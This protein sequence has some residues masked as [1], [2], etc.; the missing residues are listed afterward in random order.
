VA[1]CSKYDP[2]RDDYVLITGAGTNG[3]DCSATTDGYTGGNYYQQ[4][5]VLGWVYPAGTAYGAVGATNSL[6]TASLTSPAAGANLLVGT[7]V[8]VS[9]TATDSDGTIAKVRFFVNQKPIGTDTSSPYSVSWTPD[10]AGTYTIT[11]VALDNRGAIKKSTS[12]SVNTG[13]AARV[14]N[15][16]FS[17]PPISSTTYLSNPT[18]LGVYWTF[19][20]VWAGGQSGVTGNFSAFT[21]GQP[22]G[23]TSG[24]NSAFIQGPNPFSQVIHF[25]LAGGH[26]ICFDSAQRASNQH[27]LSLSVKFDST[28]V[29]SKQPSSLLMVNDCS[30]TFTLAAGD[31]TLNVIGVN[32]YGDDNTNFI[33]NV[34]LQ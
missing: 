3:N 19:T 25:D 23:W 34:I 31:H 10:T 22:N 8:T 18:G 33:D 17:A 28:V 11:A 4:L 5:T 16:D 20:A 30:P 27:Y 24:G 29:W 26:R 1:L 32:P 6:P 7:P 12:R 13:Y 21:N 14:L 2:T 9:A 15:P